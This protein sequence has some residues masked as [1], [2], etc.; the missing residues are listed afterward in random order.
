MSLT[1]IPTCLLKRLQDVNATTSLGSLFRCWITLSVKDFFLMSKLNL[2]W[3]SSMV[4]LLVLSFFSL[5]EEADPY[6]T[7]TFFQEAV[8]SNEISPEA[9]RPQLPQLLLTRPVLHRCEKQERMI[10][11]TMLVSA[12]A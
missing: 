1:I 12:L 7:T 11:C 3:H 6:L 2:P 4:F 8:E 5:G 10:T 9:K